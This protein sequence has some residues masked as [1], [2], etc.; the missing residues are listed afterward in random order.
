MA[1][2]RLRISNYQKESWVEFIVSD[3]VRSHASQ[4]TITFLI[5]NKGSAHG[6]NYVTFG[7]LEED[8]SPKLFFGNAVLA[9]TAPVGAPTA[10]PTVTASPTAFQDVISIPLLQDAYVRGGIHKNSNM[11]R[12]PVLIVKQ[13]S[14]SDLDRKA[15]LEFDASGRELLDSLVVLR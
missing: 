10:A 2:P 8:L 12:D 11:G 6:Q 14:N 9:P 1:G 5:E 13:H 4:S 7:S 3:L 15:I